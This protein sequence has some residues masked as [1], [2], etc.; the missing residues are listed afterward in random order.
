MRL[1][2]SL[3]LGLS[4]QTVQADDYSSELD[5]YQQLPTVLSASRMTQPLSEAPNAMTVLDRNMIVASG[6]RNI[7]DLFKLV[8]G[9]YVSYYKGS[10]PIVSY[11]GATDQYSRR[12][13]VMIDGRSVYLPPM[14]TVDWADL[15]ITVDDIERIEVIRGPAAASYGANSTQGVISIITKWADAMDGKSVSYTHGNKGI[16][17]V[18]ARFGRRGKTYDY[19]MTLAYAADNGYDNLATNPNSTTGTSLLNNSNDSNQAHLANYRGNYHPDGRN[20]YDLQFGFNHD[21]QGVGFND[22]TPN[23]AQ[24]ASTNGDPFHDLIAHS[25]FIQGG[26]KHLLEDASE[27]DLRYYHIQESQTEVFPVY[28]RGV[29][30]P[31]PIV[32]S[33]QTGRD[34]I[35]IQHML[36]TSPSNRIV[37]GAHYEMDRVAGQSIMPPLSLAYSP[38]FRT[39]DYQVFAQ[40]EWRITQR[41]L[42]NTG[43]M[44]EKDWMGRENL[45]PRIALN[46][47]ATPENTFRAGISVAYRTPSLVETNLPGVQPGSLFVPSAIPTSP[48]LMPE[49]MIS[50]EIGYLG[51]FPE[52]KTTLD[53]RAYDDLLGNG[54]FYDK[55]VAAMVNGFSAEYRGIEATLKMAFNDD[56][57]LLANFAHQTPKSNGPAL[58][59][60]GYSGLKAVYSP[61]TFGSRDILTESVPKNS[62]SLLYSQR[63][64]HDISY[65]VAYYFQDAMQPFDRNYIDFQPT[66]HRIDLR[67]AKAFRFADGV[68]GNL[69]LVV[70]NLLQQDAYTEYIASNLFNRRAYVKLTVN[71]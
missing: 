1:A 70:Q 39:N 25:S 37:Y 4:W 51:E 5:Y 57:D 33:L 29:Y 63:L 23:P 36:S 65:S 46:F 30:F 9:M 10:Q 53:L 13:Q 40:D 47:H 55:P 64:I 17:D 26:W 68:N 24:P 31:G 67:V 15:P 16:N 66:Q 34:Q 38:S 12:M 42:L 44:F 52:W 60:A 58:V 18:S 49:K 19:R 20:S 54:I 56:K 7:A 35:E 61:G 11:H 69:A 3:L 45:S 22:K 6:A 62:A 8:P 41:F 28:L 32:Q 2:V 21:V 50:R 71:W 14:N 43:G 48:N 27:L 59:A